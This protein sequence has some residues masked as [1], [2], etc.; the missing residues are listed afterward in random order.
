MS[1]E[2]YR[3]LHFV[4]LIV[5]TSCLGVSFFSKT[6]Q[7]WAKILGMTASFILMVAGMGLI[8]RTMA[9]QPWPMWVKMKL[10]LWTVIAISAPIMAKRLTNNRGI[11]FSVVMLLLVVAV[12][13]AVFKPMF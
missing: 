2:V 6:P 10:A 8:A 3:L 7:K 1:F 4:C 9:G 5:L 12:S 11:A 13:L